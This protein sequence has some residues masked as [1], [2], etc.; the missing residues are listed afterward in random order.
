[1]ALVVFFSLLFSAFGACRHPAGY[2]G[3]SWISS[4][5]ELVW[6]LVLDL[7]PSLPGTGPSL[8]F[9][10]QLAGDGAFSWI[11]PPA[12]RG[13][14]LLLDF[15]PSL[16]GT[17]PSLGFLPQ[18]AGGVPAKPGSGS[19]I[20]T[21]A[22]GR[23]RRLPM[24]GPTRPEPMSDAVIPATARARLVLRAKITMGHPRCRATEASSASGLTATG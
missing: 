23:V 9:L 21:D 16:P 8:G 12:C 15:S 18:L 22:A 6:C 7:A 19:V 20:H 11:S 13:R 1:I 17:G 14:G 5:S 24:A 2:R 4:A 10:P 3:F